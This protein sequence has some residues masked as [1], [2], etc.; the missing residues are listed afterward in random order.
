MSY[1]IDELVPLPRRLAP[2]EP[3]CGVVRFVSHDGAYGRFAEVEVDR[4]LHVISFEELAAA[5]ESHLRR[6]GFL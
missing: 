6:L 3:A 5:T 4:E 2:V 1:L